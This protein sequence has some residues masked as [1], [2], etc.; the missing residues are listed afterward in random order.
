[1]SKNKNKKLGSTTLEIKTNGKYNSLPG[2]TL[3]ELLVVVAIIGMLSSVII[4]ALGHSR[5]KSRDSRRLADVQQLRAAFDLFLSQA[6][7]YPDQSIWISGANV[8]CNGVS[9]FRVPQDPLVGFSYTYE[10]AGSASGAALCGSTWG[11]YTFSFQTEANTDLGP[12]GNYCLRPVEGVT[13]GPC[14]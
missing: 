1:M 11:S 5:I 8:S 10:H 14:P 13:S 3:I 12:P 7:G 4:L 2:F 6:G 9:L